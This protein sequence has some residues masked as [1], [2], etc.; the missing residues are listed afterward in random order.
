MSVEFKSALFWRALFRWC[1]LR[2]QRPLARS[3]ALRGA[4][5]SRA[6]LEITVPLRASSPLPAARPLAQQPGP[7]QAQQGS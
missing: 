3:S 4:A 2:G 7:A 1:G 5:V 6:A